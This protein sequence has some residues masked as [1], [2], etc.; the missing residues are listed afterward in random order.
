VQSTRHDANLAALQA[1]TGLPGHVVDVVVITADP[2]LLVTLRGASGAE[3]AI[4][5]APSADA[6][7][8]LLVGGRCGVLVAD[9][10]TLRG[11][12]SALLERLTA[13]FP[14]LILLATGRREEEGA[15]ASLISSGT[16]YRFLHKPVSP[17]RAGLFLT[18]ATRRHNELRSVEPVALATARNIAMRPHVGKIIAA[19]VAIL[20]SAVA[21]LLWRSR[22]APVPP[23][24]PQQQMPALSRDEEIADHLA[25]AEMAFA[26]GRLSEPRGDNALEHFRAVLALQPDRAEAHT[27]IDRVINALEARVV[28]ALQ[29]RNAQQGTL[30]WTALQRAQPD[31]PDLAGLQAQLVSI[32]RSMRPT[33]SAPSATPAAASPSAASPAARVAID[34][35]QPV[36]APAVA[37][38]SAGKPAAE[39][40]TAEAA[41]GQPKSPA[42]GAPSA[43]DLAAITRLRE[44]GA[45]IEPVGGNAY[46]EFIALRARFPQSAELSTEQQRI[47]FALLE[48]TRTA[49][50][51]GNVDAAAAFLTRADIVVPGMATTKTLQDQLTEARRQR[52]FMR[53]IVSAGSLKRQRDVAPVYPREARRN[54]IEGWVDVEFTIASDGTTRDLVVRN[55]QPQDVFD[56]S[57]LDS[58]SRW[59]FNPVVRDGVPVAQRASLRLKFVLQ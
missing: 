44:R 10:G 24:M 57:A 51:A 29:A 48:N 43:E 2:G 35:T 53:D 32:S 18:A 23:S 7:V 25:R 8:D 13:Q 27:G 17:A 20:V 49:L 42:A 58:V 34:E 52:D 4:W 19:V 33:L 36:A 11:D 22:E 45:L 12:A 31:H 41:A 46:D 28:A 5:H 16:V 21:F 6:A 56:K 14:E 39:A 37:R 15:V 47:A 38:D 3:H 26:T 1:S 9:L 40:P 50:A 54:G 30:A 59:R 55:S